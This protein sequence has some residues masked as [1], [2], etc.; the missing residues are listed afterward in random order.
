[1]PSVWAWSA[2]RSGRTLRCAPVGGPA[3][4]PARTRPTR[5]L[6]PVRSSASRLLF[7]CHGTR[8]LRGWLVGVTAPA[9]PAAGD[10]LP[11]SYTGASWTP[12]RRRSE[13]H[14][15]ELQSRGHLV[16]RLLLENNKRA[17]RRP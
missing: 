17:A 2:R 15:S 12:S 9:D 1:M 14:T 16:C 8:L 11:R 3:G 4:R 7:S 6:L 5:R 10:V 13:E